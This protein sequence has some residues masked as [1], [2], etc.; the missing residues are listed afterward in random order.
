MFEDKS[1]NEFSKSP[2]PF[3]IKWSTRID[4]YGGGRKE[5]AA[6]GKGETEAGKKEFGGGGEVYCKWTG[7]IRSC[8]FIPTSSTEAEVAGR[9]LRQVRNPSIQFVPGITVPFSPQNPWTRPE[10][11]SRSRA[12]T[13]F[14]ARKAFARKAGILVYSKFTRQFYPLHRIP[15]TEFS[16]RDSSYRSSPSRGTFHVYLFLILFPIY[17]PL[18][19]RKWSLAIFW[20]PCIFNNF[21]FKTNGRIDIGFK[22]FIFHFGKKEWY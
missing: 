11:R 13:S 14:H 17:S 1:K 6:W 18:L 16:G 2:Q 21:D 9:G 4:I 20:Y 15:W 5:G 10:W 7:D 12:H 8:N 22:S 3:R 19:E